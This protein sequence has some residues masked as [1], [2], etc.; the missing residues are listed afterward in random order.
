MDKKKILEQLA[1]FPTDQSKA[2]WMLEKIEE[3]RNDFETASD[4]LEDKTYKFVNDFL[5]DGTDLP[6]DMQKYIAIGKRYQ[7][8]IEMF[9]CR[10]A[11]DDCV[12]SEEAKELL[13]MSRAEIR[14]LRSTIAGT[15]ANTVQIKKEMKIM[16]RDIYCREQVEKL[17]TTAMKKKARILTE[18]A[19]SK[20]KIDT[21]I[22]EVKRDAK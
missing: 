5:T 7:D 20:Y 10:V 8:F 1:K 3:I 11:I 18:G 12:I 21:V 6:K 9:K 16:E 17:S 19:S 13:L 2:V 15:K 14:K 4:V 22:R